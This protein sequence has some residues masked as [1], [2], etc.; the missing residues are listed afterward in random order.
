MKKKDK[1]DINKLIEESKPSDEIQDRTPQLFLEWVDN[2]DY[3]RHRTNKKAYGWHQ[4]NGKYLTTDQLF[5]KF[6]KEWNKK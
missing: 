2:E 6:K 3:T 4:G 1:P 5:E